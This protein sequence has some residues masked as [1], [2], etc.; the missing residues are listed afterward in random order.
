MRK[1]REREKENENVSHKIQELVII[2][3]DWK[4]LNLQHQHNN[5]T[6]IPHMRVDPTH[7]GTPSSKGLL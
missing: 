2:G 3:Y 1:R 6:T 4:M 5:H 7:W